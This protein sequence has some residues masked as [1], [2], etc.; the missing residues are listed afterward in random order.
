MEGVQEA[1]KL[2]DAMVPTAV[3]PTIRP[4]EVTEG[5]ERA[6][7]THGFPDAPVLMRPKHVEYRDGVMQKAQQMMEMWPEVKGIFDDDIRLSFA[8][9]ALGYKGT[10]FVIGQNTTPVNARMSIPVPGWDVAPGIVSR[11]YKF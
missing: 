4:E 9:K 7:Q 10:H 2:I 5:T 11:M 6:L 3:Y 1:V 8:L